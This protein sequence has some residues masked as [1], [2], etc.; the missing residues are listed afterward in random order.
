[1]IPKRS[2]KP[3]KEENKFVVN[4]KY[5]EKHGVNKQAARNIAAKNVIEL[6]NSN[7]YTIRIYRL[8]RIWNR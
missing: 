2:I 4:P 1:M 6:Y 8:K 7:N 5:C 3:K